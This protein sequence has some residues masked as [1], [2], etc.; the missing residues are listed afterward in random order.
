VTTDRSVRCIFNKTD[1]VSFLT[2]PFT[3]KVQP[4]FKEVAT[5]LDELE[6]YT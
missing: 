1:T 2:I 3:R 6:T 5:E 4:Q